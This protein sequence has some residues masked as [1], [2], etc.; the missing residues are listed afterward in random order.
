MFPFL[1]KEY[2]DMLS[3]EVNS[4]KSP[5]SNEKNFE[6]LKEY[7]HKTLKQIY[8]EEIFKEVKDTKD[9]LGDFFDKVIGR[10]VYLYKNR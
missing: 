10:S 7:E 9:I 5:L 3:D 1:R 4:N 8:D 2:N 6:E